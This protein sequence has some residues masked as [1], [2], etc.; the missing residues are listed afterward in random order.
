MANNDS[1]GGFQPVGD[2][3]GGP[4]NGVLKKVAFA[5]GDAVAAFKGSPVK[6]TA[7]SLETGKIPVV[8]IADPADTKIAG[9]IVGFEPQRG[10]SFD[11]YHRLASTEVIAYIPADP[12]TLYMV[13]E[14]SVG[15]DID[16]SAAINH[17]VDFIGVTGSTVTGF[18]TAE[19]DS[20]TVA[21]TAGL[22]FRLHNVVERSDNTGE[23]TNAAW[24]VSINQTAELNTTG[25]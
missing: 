16:T 25:T 18:S 3:F 13:Q 23:D 17:N 24:I 6:F 12:K 15:G 4:W 21:D 19:L 7:A 20:S 11:T 10:G 5:S 14:D 9:C 22:P 2:Q 1:A 8:E